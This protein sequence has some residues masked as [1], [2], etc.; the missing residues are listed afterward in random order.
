[1]DLSVQLSN[2]RDALRRVA[3]QDIFTLQVPGTDG[4]RGPKRVSQP[5]RR[6]KPH[7]IEALVA[8]YRG[9]MTMREL[10][11]A[12]GVHRSTVSAHLHQRG[13]AIRGRGLDDG[14]LPEAVHLYEAGWSSLKLGERFS[15][16]PNTVLAALRKAGVRI[17]PAQGGPSKQKPT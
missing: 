16:T 6:L 17:R 9:G 5:Q 8:A 15:V 1:V 13:I 2:P 3:E 11:A 14:H 10:A 12:F 4:I 7:Q